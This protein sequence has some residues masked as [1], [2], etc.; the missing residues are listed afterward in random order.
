MPV[1]SARDVEKFYGARTVLKSV[2][3]TLRSGER[4][5]LYWQKRHRQVDAHRI[6]AGLEPPDRG[7]IAVRRGASVGLLE[8]VPE[9][10][11]G[12]AAPDR[13]RRPRRLGEGPRRLPRSRAKLEGATGDHDAPRRASEVGHEI[14]GLGGW[15]REHEVEAVL[16]NLGVTKTSTAT[17]R[18]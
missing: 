9:L 2:T 17:S 16:G 15:E 7:E 13:R 5:G 12:D 4:V 18:A 14:E 3:F 6:L 8:Q 10:T 1:L 11:A